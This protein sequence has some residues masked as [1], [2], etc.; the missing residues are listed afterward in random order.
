MGVAESYPGRPGAVLL[1][2]ADGN[3]SLWG[4]VSAQGSFEVVLQ[5][6]SDGWQPITDF[7]PPEEPQTIGILM[8]R[9]DRRRHVWLAVVHKLVERVHV[10]GCYGLYRGWLPARALLPGFAGAVAVTVT[11]G[12]VRHLAATD[13][14][15]ADRRIPT[16][17]PLRR[18]TAIGR[19]RRRY[20]RYTQ[21]G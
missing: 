3:S 10:S 21:R 7:V 11:S 15:V 2:R 20:F 14:V 16:V 6:G 12:L 13:V 1:V 4:T 18:R 8:H 19:S 5:T 17:S 9:V